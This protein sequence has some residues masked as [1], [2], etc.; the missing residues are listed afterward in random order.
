MDIDTYL[1]EFAVGAHYEWDQISGWDDVTNKSTYTWIPI[2]LLSAHTPD[3]HPITVNRIPYRVS[4]AHLKVVPGQSNWPSAQIY[5]DTANWAT[6]DNV[7]PAASNAIRTRISEIFKEI[8]DGDRTAIQ[9][10]MRSYWEKQ[11]NDR[12]T[13]IATKL[14]VAYGDVDAFTHS[15]DFMPPHEVTQAR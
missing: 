4:Y 2:L 7:T 8:A 5:R 14:N 10:W 12:V 3:G 9:A 6:R 13:A 1:P 11:L 15:S